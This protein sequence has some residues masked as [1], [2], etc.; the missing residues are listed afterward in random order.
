MIEWSQ[1]FL[2]ILLSAVLVFVVSSVMHTVLKYHNSDFK[3]LVNEDEVRAAV[4]KGSAT[5][6]MYMI[7]YCADHKQGSSPE[8]LRKLEE[9]PNGM[10]VL[11]A[12]GQIKIGP[13]L[14]QW[15]VY[16][17]VVS[18]LAAYVAH[19]TLQHGATY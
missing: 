2:P 17:I 3:H 10:L 15:F 8:M 12:P 9:G 7:P 16:S 14:A 1:L 18:A 11:R 5:A 13:F 6:G 19:S 4:R